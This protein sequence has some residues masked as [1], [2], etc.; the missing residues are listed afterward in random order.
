MHLVRR[1]MND[2]HMTA[3]SRPHVLCDAMRLRMDPGKM[4]PARC[5]KH[6]P[7]CKAVASDSRPAVLAAAARHLMPEHWTLLHRPS[8]ACSRHCMLALHAAEAIVPGEVS[9]WECEMHREPALHAADA[10]R[11]QEASTACH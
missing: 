5:P 6:R 8:V 3:A 4:T 2:T 1:F 9:C 10:S 11:A 7:R